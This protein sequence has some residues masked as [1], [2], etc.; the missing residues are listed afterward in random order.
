MNAKLLNILIKTNT[1][2]NPR[3]KTLSPD[4]AIKPQN[5][6]CSQTYAELEILIR[7][8]NFNLDDYI[9]S[10]KDLQEWYDKENSIF[11]HFLYF[12]QYEKGRYLKPPVI[13]NNLKIRSL[14]KKP[15]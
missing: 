2:P 4:P 10:N 5:F 6:Y 9:K 14:N 15:R 3:Q 13:S 12:G 7:D 1:V 11:L 8:N